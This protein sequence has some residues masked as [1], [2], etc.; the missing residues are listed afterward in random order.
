MDPRLENPIWHA[1][2]TEQAGL[3]ERA[4]AAAR[5][6]PAMTAL[7]ALAE[8]TAGAFAELAGLVAPG[9]VIGILLEEELELPPRLAFVDE[10]AVLQMVHDG[11]V[12]PVAE[13][14]EVLSHADN[15]AM[16]ELATLTKPGPFSTRTA[17]LGTFLGIREAGAIVAMAGQRMRLPGLIEISAVCTH[18]SQAGRGLAARLVAAQLALVHGEGAGAFL[19]VRG[20]NAR[21]IALY[22]RLGFVGRRTYRYRV[23]RAR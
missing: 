16:I 21:A 12:P 11:S 17:E 8:P 13:P 14:L 18:P 23:L 9:D 19:H 5:F 6:P 22:E 7:G 4:G 1:L 3:A 2:V 20:D 10:A 15:T